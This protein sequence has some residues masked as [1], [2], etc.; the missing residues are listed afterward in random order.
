MKRLY[1]L[2]LSAILALTAIAADQITYGELVYTIN[3]D[4]ETCIVANPRDPVTFP[5]VIPETIEDRDGKTYTVT[6]IGDNAFDRQH[7][8]SVVIPNTVTEIGEYAFRGDRM[9]SLEIP[10]SVTKIG[11]YAFN[12]CQLLTEVKILGSLTELAE[13]IFQGCTSLMS[14]TLPD[15]TTIGD[16]AFNGCSS[17]TSIDISNSV[18][19]IGK[20]AFSNCSSLTAINLPAS[21]ITI[22]DGS[23][24]GC[25]RL[26]SVNFPENLTTIGE[27]AFCNSDL[28]SI[29]L[30]ASVTTIG[31]I[32][33]RGCQSLSEV[34]S[35]GSV[36][37]LEEGIFSGCTHLQSVSLK[38]VTKIG[39]NAFNDCESLTSIEIP[40]SVTEI[41]Q[42]AFMLTGLTSVTIPES[43]TTIGNGAFRSIGN[44]E[45]ATILAPVE[46][47]GQE[48]FGECTKLNSVTLPETVTEIGEYTFYNCSSLTSINLPASL[49]TIG[50]ESFENCTG[51]KSI[52]FPET[53]KKIDNTAF[54]GCSSLTTIAFT[55]SEFELADGVFY[56]CPIATVTVYATDPSSL[57]LGRDVFSSGIFTADPKPRLIVPAGCA[58]AYEADDFWKQFNIEEIGMTIDRMEITGLYPG[59]KAEA[60]TLTVTPAGI[61]ERQPVW[62]SG[63][64]SVATVDENGVV[65]A[66]APG[67]AT[68]TARAT[69]G[70]VITAECK[71]TVEPRPV[72]G[73]ALA[74]GDER[75]E[76]TPCATKTLSVIF[77]PAD[78]TDKTVEW[79]SSDVD[80]AT[81]EAD[82]TVTAVAPGAAIVTA[83][84]TDG[85][86]ET[87]SLVI[88]NPVGADGIEIE[89]TQPVMNIGDK[90]QLRVT[91]ISDA[92]PTDKSIS[93]MSDDENV[94]PV[95]ESGVVTAVAPGT[96]TIIATTANGFTAAVRITVSAPEIAVETVTLDRTAA[97][98]VE[99]RMIRLTATVTPAGATASAVK[100][101]SSDPSVATVD[102]YGIVEGIKAGTATIT[103]EAGGKS[104]S[105]TVT[106]LAAA[107]PVESIEIAADLEMTVGEQR[108]LTA[109]V[110]PADATDK[111]LDWTSGDETI[112]TVDAHG[113]VTALKAGTV[114][115]TAVAHNSTFATCRITVT[116]NPN[117]PTDPNDPKDP[118]DPTDPDDPTDAIG[119]INADTGVSVAVADG[120]IIVSAPEGTA[121][122]VYSITGALVHTTR[123]HRIDALPR[124]IYILRI[125]TRTFKVV[126]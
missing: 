125:A 43:V 44:L 1:S 115:I 122:E 97:E 75:V 67:T 27:M 80:V 9:T 57:T 47:I 87:R 49:E 5:L 79:T 117:N 116:D 60:L 38:N 85:G 123:E 110:K 12:D 118:T 24:N 15:V 58:A 11:R 84:S 3:P 28:A 8:L 105:C 69:Y 71:V 95:N 94:A 100:W 62:E 126:L 34:K 88:V 81:V 30:P 96:A 41:G 45:T 104:T 90:Q 39:Y 26:A 64:E 63:D 77:T 114:F 21:L 61:V 18:T 7:V 10:E 102:A 65:T 56:D 89:C 23:F 72:T 31:K 99:G 50:L 93:W 32:A 70:T 66:V 83:R 76:L 40:N 111:S 92:E 2:L 16:A 22:G 101:T 53:L 108:T 74:P 68:I 54:L 52:A 113:N 20:N 6:A 86:F 55:G 19:A 106:V 35:L 33:F 91:F 112:A 36:T 29:D 82:G 48:M 4:G 37:E 51:L 13:G 78:A 103:A 17:L 42:D 109:V 121:V 14:V 98:V 124:G 25:R 120:A 73:I 59:D 119:A 107:V 46:K